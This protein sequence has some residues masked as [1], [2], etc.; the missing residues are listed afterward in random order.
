VDAHRKAGV[1]LVQKV[2]MQERSISLAAGKRKE[3]IEREG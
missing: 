1:K 2:C 3:G